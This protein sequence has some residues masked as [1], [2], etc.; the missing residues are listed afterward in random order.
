MFNIF[1]P[2]FFCNT[3]RC[4]SLTSAGGQ[5]KNLAVREKKTVEEESNHRFRIID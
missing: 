4:E 5:A 3:G 2:S 1:F